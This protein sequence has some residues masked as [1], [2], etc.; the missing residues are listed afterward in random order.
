MEVLLDDLRNDPGL[1]ERAAQRMRGQLLGLLELIGVRAQKIK[2]PF[3]RCSTKAFGDRE[4]AIAC[5]IVS[6]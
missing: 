6:D 3:C 2:R 5:R 1:K 4:H